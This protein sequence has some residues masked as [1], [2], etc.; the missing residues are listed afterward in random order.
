MERIEKGMKREN[1]GEDRN[2]YYDNMIIYMKI[3]FP[4]Y[5]DIR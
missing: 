2:M 4:S 5:R 1:R 3:F